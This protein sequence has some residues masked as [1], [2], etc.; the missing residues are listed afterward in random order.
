MAIP[1]LEYWLRRQEK[2]ETKKNKKKK[3]KSETTLYFFIPT[4]L[5]S[6]FLAGYTFFPFN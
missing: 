4:N 1:S 2:S 5:Y 6:C 3:E